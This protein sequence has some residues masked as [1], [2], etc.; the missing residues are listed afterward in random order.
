M[1]TQKDLDPQE[2][3][4]GLTSTGANQEFPFF[5]IL[6]FFF[7]R[8]NYVGIPHTINNVLTLGL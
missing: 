4:T 1:I 5:L 2:G 6:T 7:Q 8:E 3:E